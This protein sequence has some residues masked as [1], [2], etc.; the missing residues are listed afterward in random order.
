MKADEL[1]RQL[2]PFV[3]VQQPPSK[4]A[5]KKALALGAG[6][7]ARIGG[8]PADS[9]SFLLKLEHLMVATLPELPP[10]GLMVGRLPDCDLVVDDASVSKHH[11]RITWDAGFGAAVLED[12]ESSNG[13]FHNAAPVRG[14]VT[15]YDGDEILFGEVRYAYLKTRTLHAR[16]STG[17]FK[18]G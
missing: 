12:L 9:V 10:E 3:L 8:P 5:Q 1:E 18:A 13:T 2:G 6:R 15:L 14:A 4:E 16:L 7:T 17:Q 11:A